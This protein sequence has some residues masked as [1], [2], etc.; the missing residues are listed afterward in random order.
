MQIFILTSPIKVCDDTY[1]GDY[2]KVTDGISP[3]L[4][5]E[6]KSLKDAPVHTT[7]C[8]AFKYGKDWSYS[9]EYGTSNTIR[10]DVCVYAKNE[11][12]AESG[13]WLCNE[14]FD[15]YAHDFTLEIL[16]QQYRINELYAANQRHLQSIKELNE[17]TEELNK[18]L[19]LF[20]RLKRWW[21]NRRKS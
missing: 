3:P 20:Y 7:L 1:W 15:T 18:H 2:V 6:G 21:K 16:K 11:E 12:I 8:K 13:R 19:S 10:F 14:I 9:N 17:T 5:M 4:K